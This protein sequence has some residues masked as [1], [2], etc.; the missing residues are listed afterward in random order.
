MLAPADD[1][2]MADFMAQ[3]DEVN[4]LADESEGFVWRLQT[5]EGDATALRPF[6]DDQILVNM[7]V[8]ES[9]E[10]LHQFAYRTHHVDVYK[11]RRKWFEPHLG[12]YQVM[13]WVPAGHIPTV[14]EAKAR[15]ASLEQNGP[16]VQAFTFSK[17]FPAPDSQP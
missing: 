16:T 10:S 3:L 7:S 12:V 11:E 4:G 17:R 1:P 8:W 9:I 13:W 5:E 6:D 15:L 2:I 14:E